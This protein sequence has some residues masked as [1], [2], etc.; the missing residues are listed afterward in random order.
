MRQLPRIVLA[1]PAA[2]RH[3]FE[4]LRVRFAAGDHLL[5]LTPGGDYLATVWLQ[6]HQVDSLD[7]AEQLL[8]SAEDHSAG[9]EAATA[10][11]KRS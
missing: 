7:A 1:P 3:R 8:R 5:Q 2:D 4:S 10:M 9:A 6:T 11:E